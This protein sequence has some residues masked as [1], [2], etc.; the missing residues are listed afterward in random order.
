MAEKGTSVTNQTIY[1]TEK[2]ISLGLNSNFETQWD[3]FAAVPVWNL[4]RSGKLGVISLELNER[5]EIKVYK[6]YENGK[7]YEK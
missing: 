2:G 6:I 7:K 4:P 1:V 5:R 3:S